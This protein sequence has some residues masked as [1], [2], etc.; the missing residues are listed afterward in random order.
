VALLKPFFPLDWTFFGLTSDYKVTLLEEIYV[1]TKHIGFTRQD[2]MLMPVYERKY[3][4]N[5]LIEENE[6]QQEQIQKMK[7][8]KR[9]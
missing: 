7:K 3:H 6:K 2:V 8:Q 5:K 9:G 4:I 1:C